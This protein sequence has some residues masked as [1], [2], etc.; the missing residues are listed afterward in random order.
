MKHLSTGT[1]VAVLGVCILA[2]TV[3]ATQRGGSEAFA[4][5]PPSPRTIIA[6]GIHTN[7]ADLWMYR[8]WSDNTCEFRWLC[9]QGTL[10][11]SSEFQTFR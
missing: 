3:V 8:V 6:A 4:Q 11:L 2:A 9:K 10:N 5:A 7:N 1:G